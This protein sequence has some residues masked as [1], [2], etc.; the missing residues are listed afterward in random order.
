MTTKRL[1]SNE[2]FVPCTIRAYLPLRRM[3]GLVLDVTHRLQAG[4]VVEMQ[5]LQARCDRGELGHFLVIET[6]SRYQ[7]YYYDSLKRIPFEMKDQ[8]NAQQA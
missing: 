8:T 1:S 3:G 4:L 6:G 7:S 5:A 2:P